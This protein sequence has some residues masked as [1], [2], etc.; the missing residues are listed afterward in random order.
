MIV[1]ELATAAV[2][3]YNYER[4][5]SDVYKALAAHFDYL[6][7]TGM[8]KY[9]HGRADEETGHA[10][11][12]E[13]YLTDRDVAVE[14]GPIDTRSIVSKV[15][16]INDIVSVGKAAFQLALEHER[17]VT[18]RLKKLFDFSN[19]SGDSQMAVF[20]HWFLNEQVEEEKSLEEILTKFDLADNGTGILLIDQQMGGG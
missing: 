3:Q 19:K 14:L 4:L 1:P 9:M 12:F 11:K 6:N 16:K 2:S 10:S 5:S 8:A 7:L 20:L 15:T 17:S 18:E 13:Q